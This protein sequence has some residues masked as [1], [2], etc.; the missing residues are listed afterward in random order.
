M[1]WLKNK[2]LD[3]KLERKDKLLFLIFAT[4]FGR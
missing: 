1:K 3:N 4:I 2:E